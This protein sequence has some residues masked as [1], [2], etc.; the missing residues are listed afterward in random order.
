MFEVTPHR[1]KL[2]VIVLVG[3]AMVG[4]AIRY[5]APNPS[6][7]R[8]LGSLLLVLWLPVIGNVIGFFVRKIR[9]GRSGGFP[10]GQPF[11]AHLRIELT[12]LGE[13]S[14]PPPGDV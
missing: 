10:A 1:R 7:G 5:W 12:P 8:D 2:V 9:I 4:G 14:A 11:Q 3:L 6:T 13:Q